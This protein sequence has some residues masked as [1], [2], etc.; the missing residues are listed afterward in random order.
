MVHTKQALGNHGEVHFVLLPQVTQ[1]PGCRCDDI[2]K[3]RLSTQ[4][5]ITQRIKVI[6]NS[7]GIGVKTGLR[8][9]EHVLFGRSYQ[10]ALYLF[11]AQAYSARVSI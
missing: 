8:E 6:E 9:I 5:F 1:V 11:K 3:D 4:A 7:L 10:F 2:Q